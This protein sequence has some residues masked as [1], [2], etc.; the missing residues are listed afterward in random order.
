MT[1]PNP[2]THRISSQCRRWL[3]NVQP[4]HFSIGSS[5]LKKHVSLNSKSNH[6]GTNVDYVIPGTTTFDSRMLA[7]TLAEEF[8]RAGGHVIWIGTT[9]DLHRMSEQLLFKIAGLELPAEGIEVKFDVLKYLD[10]MDARAE[11]MKMWIDFC[12]VEDCGD[13]A[14][15]QEFIAS[16]SSFK[17][18]LIVVDESVF[19]DKTLD[20]FEFLIRNT[21]GLHM[22]KRLRETNPMCNIL[23]PSSVPT[24]TLTTLANPQDTQ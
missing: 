8:A 16:M 23:W 18:T 1:S 12:N 6:L 19:D 17:P 5:G 2:S 3:S 24:S 20:P 13:V 7:V 10:L 4:S 9:S 15:E 22:V 14:L 11:M 21:S